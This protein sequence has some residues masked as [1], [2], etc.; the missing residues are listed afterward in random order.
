HFAE[1]KHGWKGWTIDIV[2]TDVSASAIDQAREGLYSSF[3]VQRGLSVMQMMRW[4]EEQPGKGWA[5]SADL[6]RQVRF[7]T[8]NLLADAPS[9]GPVDIILCRNVLLYFGADQR[10]A[11]FRRLRSALAPDGVLMLGAGETVIGQTDDFVSDPD[12]RGLYLPADYGSDVSKKVSA[13]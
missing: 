13:R 3:E 2:G 10:R 4:F 7:E 6:K 1:Q 11:A 9:G 5:V 8:G 12:C